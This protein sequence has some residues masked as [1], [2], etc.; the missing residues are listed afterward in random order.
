MTDYY[1]FYVW[2]TLNFTNGRI[3]NLS[4]YV[5]TNGFFVSYGGVINFDNVEMISLLR[6]VRNIGM[7][8]KTCFW[9]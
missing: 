5:G 4:P 1:W 2:G 6:G 3:I 9:G 7:G 8:S